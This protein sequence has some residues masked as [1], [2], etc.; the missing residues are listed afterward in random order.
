MLSVC[1]GE[2]RE[3]EKE[4]EKKNRDAHLIFVLPRPFCSLPLRSRPVTCGSTPATVN[5]L[6]RMWL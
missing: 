5:L 3:V 6:E 4:G 1:V 2:K